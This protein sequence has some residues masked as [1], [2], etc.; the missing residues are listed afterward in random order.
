MI[1]T[2]PNELNRSDYG[3]SRRDRGMILWNERHRPSSELQ[4][5]EMKTTTGSLVAVLLLVV[6]ATANAADR[7]CLV[8]KPNEGSFYSNESLKA[9]IG[10]G[11]F[12]FEPGGSGFVDYDGA[13]GIKFAFVRLVPGRLY[14]GG[15]RL[16]GEA[17]P[18]QAYI[19]D[20]PYG[21]G[22]QGFQ[23]IYLVFPFAATRA[24]VTHSGSGHSN[25]RR[26]E[27]LQ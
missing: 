26:S 15:R 1:A 25:W 4:V 10:R 2:A 18:A 21:S 6:A 7:E 20:Y 9:S 19:Y 14:V 23:P 17:G 22:Y 11:H 12:V 27:I 24:T 3:H 13:L 8:T 16:D 5:R